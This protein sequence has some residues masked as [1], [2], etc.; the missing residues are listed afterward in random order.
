[1]TWVPGGTGMACCVFWWRSL[2]ITASFASEKIWEKSGA[3][4]WMACAPEQRPALRHFFPASHLYG[5][6][7]ECIGANLP[8]L[9]CRVDNRMTSR[10]LKIQHGKRPKND[11]AT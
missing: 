7:I 8:S 6:P 5:A 2:K 1:M 9:D 4:G 3:A 10:V 11:M